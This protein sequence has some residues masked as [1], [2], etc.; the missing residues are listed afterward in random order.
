MNNLYR[1]I[2]KISNIRSAYLELAGKFDES[3]KSSKYSGIDGVSLKDIDNT[4]E[5]LF[6]QIRK[7]LIE[8]TS[9]THVVQYS[10]PKSS[11]NGMR[12]IFIYTVKERIKA[13]AIYRIVE[14][15]FE[16][17]YSEFL[18]S[19]RK[20]KP[21]YFAARSTVRRYKRRY[22][23]DHLLLIDFAAYS[24]FIDHGILIGKLEKLGFEKN[25]MDLLKLFIN[26]DVFNQNRKEN[27]KYGLMQG[28]PLIALFANI[29]LNDLDHKIGKKVQFYRR[30]GDDLMIA[31]PNKE[32]LDEIFKEII[33][34]SKTHRL[35]I[36]KEKTKQIKNSE[37]FNFLG[38]TFKN[39]VVSIKQS[40]IKRII[41]RWKNQLQYN[42]KTEKQKIRYV[43]MLFTK[44]ENN[45]DTQFKEIVRQ[46]M[47]TDNQKQIKELYNTFI[48]L[49]VKFIYRTYSERNHRLTL[50]ALFPYKMPSLYKYFID[51]HNGK[52]I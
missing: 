4:S 15:I 7:E 28:V 25:T 22:D 50:E 45:L 20:T 11:G 32:K 47:F 9:I 37:E 2:I 41:V 46:Y 52:K 33:K 27:Q 5:E 10:I 1:E 13:Q 16:D 24:D 35:Q 36:K 12:D 19:Y 23:K 40:G 29:Y 51:L 3:S 48:K 39:N 43:K 8:L 38:Y 26:V 42:A 30:V 21:S 49:V 44:E 18:F 17:A 34:L 14:P 31:D 6:Q